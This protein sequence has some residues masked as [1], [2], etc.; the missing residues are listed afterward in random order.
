MQLS[1]LHLRLDSHL[2]LL[3]KVEEVEVGEEASDP[4]L[5]F[6]EAYAIKKGPLVMNEV[7]RWSKLGGLTI[8]GMLTN[9]T[10]L[11]DQISQSNNACIFQSQTFGNGGEI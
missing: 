11:Q 6:E 3:S 7:G 8:P 1:K 5:V 2:Y 4:G 9:V 10:M